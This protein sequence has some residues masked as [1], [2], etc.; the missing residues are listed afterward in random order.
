MF[1]K[2]GDSA[3]TV[4]S[5]SKRKIATSDLKVFLKDWDREAK[6]KGHTSQ[7]NKS[8][9][10][11]IGKLFWF[12]EHEKIEGVGTSELKDFIYYLQTAHETPEGRWGNPK[13]NTPM[14]QISVCNYHRILKAFFNFCIEDELIDFNPMRK[15]K[16]EAPQKELKQPVSP[17]NIKKLMDATRYGQNPK[18]DFAVLMLL[19]DSGARA[20]EFCS[21]RR[22]DFDD[23][24]RI[25]G[26]G[27]KIRTIHLAPVTVKAVRKYLRAAQHDE[28]S[29][30]LFISRKT[31]K[32]LTPGGLY[33]LIE[34]LA[35]RAEIE[36]PGCHAFRRTFAVTLLRNGENVFTVQVLLGHADLTMTQI[37][38][39]VADADIAEAH[40]R[41]SPVATLCT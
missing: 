22:S 9:S 2:A 15:V 38:N 21:I 17:E 14:R 24:I 40:K 32:A 26:K 33:Q 31:G 13:C 36:N 25:N 18:R 3:N 30:A 4:C 16:V 5:D 37:Y 27:D 35:D 10:L 8:R 39:Q 11:R 29:D 19:L 1:H 34:R 12:L 7:S 6:I 20:S 23:T 28:M 41:S